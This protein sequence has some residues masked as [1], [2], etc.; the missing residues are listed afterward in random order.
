M[1]TFST[2]SNRRQL[3][4]L[5]DVCTHVVHDVLLQMLALENC[6]LCDNMERA[7]IWSLSFS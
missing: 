4:Y 5:C 1:Q 2:L 3:L 7:V 6:T